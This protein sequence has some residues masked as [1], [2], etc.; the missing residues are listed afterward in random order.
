MDKCNLTIEFSLLTCYDTFS[1]CMTDSPIKSNFTNINNN[2][3]TT[4]IYIKLYG[5]FAI[6][7]GKIMKPVHQWI[8]HTKTS[9]TEVFFYLHLDEW[10]SKQSWGWWFETPSRPFWRHS[11]VF[12]HIYIL[13]PTKKNHMVFVVLWINMKNRYEL[14]PINMLVAK[15]YG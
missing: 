10:W 6:G 7:Y 9:D 3:M 11:N 14:N 4:A 13:I 12:L 5:L 1:Q 8:P 15:I 2:T